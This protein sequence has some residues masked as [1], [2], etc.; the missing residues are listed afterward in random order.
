[1]LMMASGVESKFRAALDRVGK[2]FKFGSF[3]TGSF[4]FTGI[5]FRQWDDFSVEYDQVDYVEK[6]KPIEISK[7]RRGQGES[8]LTASEVTQ[9]RSLT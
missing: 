9:L 7:V 4:T 1:M 3:E 2:R 6:I 5:R 8:S